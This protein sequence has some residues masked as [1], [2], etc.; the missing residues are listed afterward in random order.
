MRGPKVF[1]ASF[2]SRDLFICFLRKEFHRNEFD[3]QRDRK[4]LKLNWV[5]SGQAAAIQIL[6]YSRQSS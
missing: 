2:K 1:E 3:V 5:Q 4:S 6:K